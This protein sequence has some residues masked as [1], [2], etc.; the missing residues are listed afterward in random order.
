MKERFL[1]LIIVILLLI[2]IAIGAL[3][4][5]IFVLDKNDYL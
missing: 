1:P 5:K 4:V 3:C 2:V